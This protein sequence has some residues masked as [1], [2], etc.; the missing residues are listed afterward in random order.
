[1]NNQNAEPLACDD[2]DLPPPEYNACQGEAEVKKK[3]LIPSFHIIFLI[4]LGSL[5]IL[6][7]IIDMIVFYV[8]PNNQIN[9][10]KK[11]YTNFD[12]DKP[13]VG[14]VVIHFLLHINLIIIGPIIISSIDKEFCESITFLLL[15]SLSLTCFGVF[16]IVEAVFAGS[17]I[18]MFSKEDF[19]LTPISDLLI[20]TNPISSAFF[21]IKGKVS[22]KK[23]KTR[24]CYSKNGFTL[25]IQSTLFPPIF[26]K[27][28]LNAD[29]FYLKI[30]QKINMTDQLFLWIEKS[31]Q[32][33][34]S[35]E[36]KHN[37]EIE[38]YPI[39]GGTHLVLTEGKKIPAKMKKGNAIASLLFGLGIYPELLIKSIPVKYFDQNVSADVVPGFDYR[40]AIDA[41]DCSYIGKCNKKNS[42][43]SM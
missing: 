42:K 21:Y 28:E 7:G 1:M 6:L 22:G 25:P 29:Y 12:F 23:G 3:P 36:N 16:Y 17:Y 31:K 2:D 19:Q 27:N 37:S 41:I 4:I 38:Y 40:A 13:T 26:N 10:N 20:S 35:C 15:I 30:S 32:K 9:K 14:I 11:K 24:T 33:L 43:P 5:C 8:V 39:V 34:V 18:D